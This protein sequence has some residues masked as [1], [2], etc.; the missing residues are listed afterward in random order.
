MGERP[1]GKTLDRIDVNGDYCKEN[2]RWATPVEQA[3]NK[4]RKEIPIDVSD[5]VRQPVSVNNEKAPF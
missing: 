1:E 3:G 4:R 5:I 2:C